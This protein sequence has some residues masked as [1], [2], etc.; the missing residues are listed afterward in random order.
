MPKARSYRD[1]LED[2][3]K[4]IDFIEKEEARAPKRRTRRVGLKPKTGTLFAIRNKRMAIREAALRRVQIVLTYKKITTGEV[5]KYIV[6]P[7]EWKNR[8]LKVGRR[9]VLWAYDMEAKRIKSF[10]LRSVR[11]V[12]LTNRKFRPKWPVKIG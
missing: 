11:N 9:K 3:L 12:A 6:A 10:V 2:G 1:I 7:Y 5:K 8:V 4:K